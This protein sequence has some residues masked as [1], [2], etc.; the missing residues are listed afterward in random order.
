M[1]GGDKW[2]PRAKVIVLTEGAYEN[3]LHRDILLARYSH[4]LFDDVQEES[5]ISEV[6]YAHA[7]AVI[8]TPHC[9]STG[10]LRYDSR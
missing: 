9:P 6:L 5:A 8:R 1:R 3:E 2:S 10:L 7:K 4:V